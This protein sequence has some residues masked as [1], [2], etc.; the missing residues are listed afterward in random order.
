MRGANA[1][2]TSVVAVG[3]DDKFWTKENA[4]PVFA[5]AA[6]AIVAGILIYKDRG[7]RLPV[8]GSGPTQIIP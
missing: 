1:A 8:K 6:S 4:I 3:H 7:D 5:V 2:S